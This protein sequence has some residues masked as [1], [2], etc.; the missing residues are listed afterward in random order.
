MFNPIEMEFPNVWMYIKAA[1]SF[2][3]THSYVIQLY[4][5]YVAVQQQQLHIIDE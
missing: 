2:E 4:Y 3:R 1:E 5:A